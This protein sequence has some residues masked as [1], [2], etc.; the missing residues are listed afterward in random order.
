MVRA[1]VPSDLGLGPR[2]PLRGGM[3][4][5]R[6]A[7]S[8]AFTTDAISRFSS[9]FLVMTSRT[10]AANFSASEVRGDGILTSS[11][12]CPRV[13]ITSL[14]RSAGRRAEAIGL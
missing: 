13:S 9:A 2:Q 11:I 10:I 14:F 3:R 1:S 12:R 8:R 7:C 6:Y 5:P 4:G